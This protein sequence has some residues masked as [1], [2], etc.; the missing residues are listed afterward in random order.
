MLETYQAHLESLR[1]HYHRASSLDRAADIVISI[2]RE[3]DAKCVATANLPES[4][5]A[6]V[7]QRCS[8][9]NVEVLAQ[10]YKN[11]PP[12]ANEIDRAAVGITS[13]DFAIAQT[14]TLVEIS[15]N[16]DVRLVSSLPRTHIGIV[17]ED[18]FVDSLEDASPMLRKYFAESP[19][20]CVASFISGPS[21]TGDIELRLTLGVHGPEIVH[22][23]VIPREDVS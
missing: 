8:D 7:E 21:R 3:L 2:I 12:L 5:Q 22:T 14:S 4:F 20:N 18:A 9:Y 13:A 11:D 19:E 15:T 23:I 17:Y 6:L 1:G 16:D 10:P